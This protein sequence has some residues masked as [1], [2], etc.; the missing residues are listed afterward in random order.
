MGTQGKVIVYAVFALACS[1]WF[2]FAT[3]KLLTGS[4]V[5][6]DAQQNLR[7]A[8]HLV[9]TGTWGYDEQETS[10]PRPTMRREP[11]PI[12][13]ISALLLLHPSF[14]EPYKIVDISDGRLTSTVKLV[15]VFWRFLASLFVFLL[16]LELFARPITA[17]VAALIAL[18]ISDMTFLSA[19]PVVDQLMTEL[20]AAA[21]LLAASWCA[22]RFVRK[23]NKSRAICLGLAIGLLALTKAAYLYIGIVFILVL[24]LVDRVKLFRQPNAQSLRQLRVNYA[25]LLG[26]FLLT[27]A[28]W[29]VRNAVSM[30]NFGIAER[31]ED[32]I[33]LR[34]LLAE[35]PP[36]GM[37]YAYSPS[38]LQ[39]RLGSVL[40][41]SRADLASG[42]R[43]DGITFVKERRWEIYKSRMEA[44]GY[45]RGDKKK[46]LRN[47]VVSSVVNDPLRYFS[48]VG[49]FAY[50]GMWF[51]RPSGIA[52][53]LDPM[54][55]Y[56]MSALS[57]LCFLGV[58]FGGLVARNKVLIAAFGLGAG[59][60]LFY[61]A[62]SHALRR[63]NAPLTPL[64][65]ISVIW[66]CVA[67]F[68]GL[69]Q[70]RQ[71]RRS[72]VRNGEG[73]SSAARPDTGGR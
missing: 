17:G 21:L 43:L 44:E 22:V 59:S 24:F 36:L 13:A 51:M 4:A 69:Q 27:L 16:C 73:T 61:S 1:L 38:P 55:F 8:Y 48:S 70:W 40:G 64:V 32:V 3:T 67:L 66:L 60:F 42:G 2:G 20:P 11:L 57:V 6:K 49:V 30:G 35:E 31:A 33:G 65:I 39:R 54:T 56:V 12:L 63:Y 23:Q 25:V 5:E 28:P 72:P 52:S 62:L 53:R 46:W 15:N 68:S 26:A 71:S 7:I 19:P 37:I 50:R 9:H 45:R 41:Y 29:L 14:A 47:S 34:M 18:A 58:F 10:N